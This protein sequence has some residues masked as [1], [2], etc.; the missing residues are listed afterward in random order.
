LFGSFGHVADES[1]LV[2]FQRDEMKQYLHKVDD[3]LRRLD[4]NADNGSHTSF[5]EA[6]SLFQGRDLARVSFQSQLLPSLQVLLQPGELLRIELGSRGATLGGTR[7][8]GFEIGGFRFHLPHPV[9]HKLLS[10][11][12]AL[13]Q[14]CHHVHHIPKLLCPDACSADRADPQ[15]FFLIQRLLKEKVL[16]VRYA[17]RCALIQPIGDLLI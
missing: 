10:V 6:R 9:R 1:R 3:L 15:V 17:K 2:F 16:F 5:H 8:R 14:L 11:F 7:R 4:E 12:A 13:A